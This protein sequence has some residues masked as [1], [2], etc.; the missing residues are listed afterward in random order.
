MKLWT[1]VE[2][3]VVNTS[4]E[5]NQSYFGEFV[6]LYETEE[7]AQAHTQDGM[8]HKELEASTQNKDHKNKKRFYDKDMNRF[9]RRIVEVETGKTPHL[10]DGGSYDK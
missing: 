5:E 2:N 10:A 4:F 7:Q 6:A 8:N 3:G 9:T 1:V